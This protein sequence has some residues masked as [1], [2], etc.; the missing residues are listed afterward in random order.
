[1]GKKPSRWI[2]TA[3]VLSCGVLAT[4]G[5]QQ[6]HEAGSSPCTLLQQPA[7][8]PDLPEASGLAL[9]LRSPGLLWSHNDSSE[10]ALVAFDPSGTVRGRVRVDNATVTDWEDVSAASCPSGPCLFIADIGDNEHTRGD[11]TVYRVAEPA[12]DAR[13]T[14]TELFTVSYPDGPHDAEALFVVGNDLFV[15]TKDAEAR[16]Y[17]ASMDGTQRNLELKQIAR[18]NLTRVTDAETSRD[19]TWVL[20]RTSNE[21]VFYR[22][23][24]IV[25]GGDAPRGIHVP[26]EWAKEP[27]GE[28]VAMDTDGT[29]HLSSEGGGGKRA[30]RLTSLRCS[31]PSPPGP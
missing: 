19:G 17:R 6:R 13:T 26:V 20:V 23:A 10:P 31:L 24:D 22:T 1:M 5:A 11:V 16:V 8:L 30:G 18:L 7:S 3:A 28:G 25:G 4:A 15:V 2:G 12:P 29:L 21:V 14:R 9:S 27:Q